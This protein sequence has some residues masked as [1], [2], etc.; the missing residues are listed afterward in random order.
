MDIPSGVLKFLPGK[1]E[2]VEITPCGLI[3][4]SRSDKITQVNLNKSFERGIHCWEF[5]CPLS[6]YGI[7]FGLRNRGG[8][9]EETF[10]FSASTPRTITFKLDMNQK[11][12]KSW[13]NNTVHT[14]K[15]VRELNEGEWSPFVR[16]KEKGN[17]V[18]LNPFARDPEQHVTLFN[19][20]KNIEGSTTLEPFKE[21]QILDAKKNEKEDIN[22]VIKMLNKDTLALIS[23]TSIRLLYRN[24]KTQQFDFNSPQVQRKETEG[25]K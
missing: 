22:H 6:C 9:K 15:P 3:L 18:I 23:E 16:I 1:S 20:L 25:V 8:R 5:H 12:W 13:I 14:R 17:I 21:I 11:V 7:T 2:S 4:V 19:P 10:E 24:S